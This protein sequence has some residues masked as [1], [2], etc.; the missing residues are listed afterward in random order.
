MPWASGAVNAVLAWR[1]ITPDSLGLPQEAEPV[2]KCYVLVTDP[3]ERQ[4][5]GGDYFLLN[6]MKFMKNLLLIDSSFL[7]TAKPL[8]PSWVVAVKKKDIGTVR[9][10]L[11]NLFLRGWGFT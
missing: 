8:I 5:L 4:P 11:K 3:I 10:Q 7:R 9:L 1:V 2:L 6:N